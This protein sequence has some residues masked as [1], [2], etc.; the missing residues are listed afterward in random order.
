MVR[1]HIFKNR[2]PHISIVNKDVHNVGNPL[3]IDK[4][5]RISQVRKLST[6][7]TRRMQERKTLRPWRCIAKAR[8]PSQRL[9]PKHYSMHFPTGSLAP[10][11]QPF[12]PVSGVSLSAY[13]H[14][15][16]C[17]GP[18]LLVGAAGPRREAVTPGGCSAM[19]S[20]GR[21]RH[22]LVEPRR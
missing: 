1:R 19:V 15:L 10:T 21:L 8:N 12:S 18:K 7:K 2:S 13:R 17:L 4:S 22:C 5:H 14:V 6:R 16:T 20:C 11:P 3:S 9:E